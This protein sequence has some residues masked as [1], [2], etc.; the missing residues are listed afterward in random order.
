MSTG[1]NENSEILVDPKRFKRF[2]HVSKSV[3]RNKRPRCQPCS[4]DPVRGNAR[5]PQI[6]GTMEPYFFRW[7]KPAPTPF[8]SPRSCADMSSVLPTITIQCCVL[9]TVS[10]WLF[11]H[12]FL[13]F[14]SMLPR[15]KTRKTRSRRKEG[16]VEPP[17]LPVSE[18]VGP[19]HFFHSPNVLH[20]P[21]NFR[22]TSQNR[23]GVPVPGQSSSPPP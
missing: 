4:G 5:G 6:R 14:V 11:L 19:P 7:S 21:A 15:K 16:R 1:T 22:L 2:F 17:P 8:A 12:I 20:C 3:C 9:A 23:E 18:K 13:R 10:G